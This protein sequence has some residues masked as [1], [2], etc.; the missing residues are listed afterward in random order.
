MARSCLA[1]MCF[2]FMLVSYEF[3]V[4]IMFDSCCCL[5]KKFFSVEFILEKVHLSRM[6]HLSIKLLWSLSFSL[7]WNEEAVILNL[8]YLRIASTFRSTGLFSSTGDDHKNYRIYRHANAMPLESLSLSELQLR[9]IKVVPPL[10]LPRPQAPPCCIFTL[11]LGQR[12][13]VVL[14]EWGHL[15]TCRNL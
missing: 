1:M 11:P 9:K 12:V 5:F 7:D 2:F 8:V 3:L 6:L 10:L 14:K 4:V 13:V 15:H